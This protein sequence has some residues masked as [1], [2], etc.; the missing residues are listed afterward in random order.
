MATPIRSRQG[1]VEAEA[2]IIKSADVMDLTII[3]VERFKLGLLPE[4][5]K[6]KI[7]DMID[8]IEKVIYA[9]TKDWY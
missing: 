8:D 4:N 1:M 2:E 3:Y 7:M 5:K 9:Y 6:E